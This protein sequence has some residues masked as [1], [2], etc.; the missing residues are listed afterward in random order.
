M[1]T[2][3]FIPTVFHFG[4][5]LTHIELDLLF[6]Y[7]PGGYFDIKRNHRYV[8]D[9]QKIKHGDITYESIKPN[10]TMDIYSTKYIKPEFGTSH[11]YGH[12]TV[13]RNPLKM[14]SVLEPLQIGSCS[15]KQ[16]SAVSL[17]AKQENCVVAINAGF[18]NPYKTQSNYG[19]CYG[20]II[21]NGR[22]V[23]DSGGIQN[24]NFGIRKDGTVV[25]GY[26]S[27]DNVD[28]KENPFVQLI[29]GVGWVLRNGESY[30]NESFKAECAETQTTASLDKFFRV[31][32]AR[33][34]IGYDKNGYVHIIQ[35]DGKTGQTG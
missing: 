16:L 2:L 30:L 23:Q 13:V 12:R 4:R 21:S 34:L 3:L 26:L 15:K 10:Q 28:D 17:S 27:Q 11:Q 32:S 9:C 8:R 24:A 35:F 20:N 14:L 1:F 33:T 31:K 6:P 18:F 25:I 19:K 5:A 22:L 7:P 29:A